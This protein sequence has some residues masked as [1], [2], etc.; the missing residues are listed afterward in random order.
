MQAFEV[1]F[2]AGQVGLRLVD[3]VARLIEGDLLVL[4]VGLGD[5]DAGFARRDREAG[6][7]RVNF[8]KR[9]ALLHHLALGH[10]DGFDAARHFRR[11]VVDRYR[12]DFARRRDLRDQ[13]R[14][15]LDLADLDGLALALFKDSRQGDD[16]DESDDHQRD[17][18]GLFPTIECHNEGS[19][20]RI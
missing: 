12:A 7:R 1:G 17:D 9:L 14:A 8:D 13:L 20:L 11:Q 16:G 5:A 19:V 4:H 2:G 6:L 18:D 10:V 15:A 3:V